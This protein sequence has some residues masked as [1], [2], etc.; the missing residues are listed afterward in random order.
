MDEWFLA[1]D[2]VFMD[3]AQASA[4]GDGARGADILVLSSHQIATVRSWCSRVLWLDQGQDR[5]RRL[6]RRS[7]GSV[8]WKTSPN[9]PSKLLA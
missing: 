4:G 6:S 8:S 7:T 2:A 1:G 3:K 9:N 5:G